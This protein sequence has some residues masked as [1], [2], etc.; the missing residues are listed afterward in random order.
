MGLILKIPV[1]AISN[2]NMCQVFHWI[3]FI[4]IYCKNHMRM[5]E[6]SEDYL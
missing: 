6:T 4:L 5:L 1:Y 3:L 2:L